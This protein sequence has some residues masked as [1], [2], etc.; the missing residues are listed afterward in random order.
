M[1]E[2]NVSNIDVQKTEHGWSIGFND[3]DPTKR[4]VPPSREETRRLVEEAKREAG[5]PEEK[6]GFFRRLFE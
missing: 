3:P 1:S 5:E 4:Y 2:H 6:K